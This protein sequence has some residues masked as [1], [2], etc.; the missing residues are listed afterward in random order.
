MTFHMVAI[1]GGTVQSHYSQVSEGSSQI[2]W[3]RVP[4]RPNS[5]LCMAQ[6][7]TTPAMRLYQVRT[8]SSS[9]L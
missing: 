1:F 7:S 8:P 6:D 3:S 9:A 4:R 2:K 5:I